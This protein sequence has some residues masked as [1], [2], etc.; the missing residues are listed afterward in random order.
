MLSGDEFYEDEITCGPLAEDDT[1]AWPC[2]QCGAE[3]GEDC[4]PWCTALPPHA[5]D[6]SGGGFGILFSHASGMVWP[7]LVGR[8][9]PDEEAARAYGE[10]VVQAQGGIEFAVMCRRAD[11]PGWMEVGTGQ[12]V[13]QVV[14]R[15]WSERIA[16]RFAAGALH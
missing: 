4:R 12:N 7:D 14:A 8:A 3:P 15:Q 10:T 2:D 11:R 1:Y 16:G 5:Q 6:N 13:R 9:F